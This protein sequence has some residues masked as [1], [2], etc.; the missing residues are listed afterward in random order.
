[1]TRARLPICTGLFVICLMSQALFGQAISTSNPA[2]TQ[3][4]PSAGA[5]P[6]T[7]QNTI[8]MAL[9]TNLSVIL[10]QQ[11]TAASRGQKLRVL[12]QLLPNVTS[13][14]AEHLNQENLATF[15]IQVP[16]IPTIVGPFSF[17]DARLVLSQS[18]FDLSR[19]ERLR[20]AGE[21]VSTAQFNYQDARNLIVTAAASAYLRALSDAARITAA[22][23]Q[24]DTARA[25]YNKAVDLHN[26]GISPAIDS[27]RAQV[28]LQT[29]EQQLIV[30]NNAYA[31]D[32][33]SIARAIGLPLVQGQHIELTEKIPYAPLASLTLEAAIERAANTRPDLKSA[34]SSLRSAELGRKAA[35]AQYLPTFAADA[36][37]GGTG[38]TPGSSEST[39]HVTGSVRM[40]IFQGGR[41]RGDVLVADAAVQQ[42]RAQANDLRLQVEF[43]VRSAFLDLTSTAE[44]VRVTT[45]SVGL[46]KQALTQAQD[47][48]ASGVAD[49]LEVVQA[50]EAYASANESYIASLYSYNLSKLGLAR[51]LGVAEMEGRKFVEGNK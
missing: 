20:A 6:L 45:S 47:R 16:G 4:Q 17:F 46:A 37:Y 44:Q 27:V 35:S 13:G 23:A 48:F 30:A 9:R 28:E 32:L 49:N 41:I 22:Q 7:L 1:M 43:E 19:I 33:L 50:Q 12:S 51:A 15:G 11:A 31:K 14:V 26:A 5:V 36:D 39:F 25:L 40:P 34:L 18:L 10:S 42:Q 2:S 8:D 38:L 29:R 21:D 24:V 3:S